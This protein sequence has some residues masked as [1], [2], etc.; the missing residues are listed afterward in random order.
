MGLTM[1]EHRA[2]DKLQN[3]T[4]RDLAL[5]RFPSQKSLGIGALNDAYKPKEWHRTLIEKRL[6]L[7]SLLSIATEYKTSFAS[8]ARHR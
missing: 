2:Q 5:T 1:T 4:R 8:I 6:S 7:G 3:Y